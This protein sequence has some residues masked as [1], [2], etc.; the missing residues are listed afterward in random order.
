MSGHDALA[1]LKG[2]S[3]AME[4]VRTQIQRL[5][6]S[7]VPILIQ[8]ETGTGKELCAGAV[9]QLSGRMPFVP[10]NCAAFPESLAESELFGHERGAF[11]GA[12]R[13][14]TGVVA[15]A[16]GGVL[17]LDEL[18]ELPPHMQAKL[19]R[20]LESGEYRPVGSNRSLRSQFRIL[21]ATSGDL[22]RVIAEGRL[23]A[24]L[25]HRLGAVRI[26]MPPLRRRRDDIPLLACEFLHRYLERSE[27]GP[28]RI[29]ADAYAILVAFDWPGNV[30]QL[31]NVVEGAAAMAGLDD[32]IRRA[33][34][35]QFVVPP[36]PDGNSH[37]VPSLAQARRSA[38]QQAIVDA[39]SRVGGNRERAAK[40]LRVSPATLYRRL[41][42][43]QH[44]SA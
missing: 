24:D 6:R 32:T 37:S 12:V 19:L 31:R 41:G 8:G 33:H 7:P 21:A 1:A 30:R 14:H 28:V 36:S 23:R 3:A 2:V 40:L 13:A 10:I 34:V 5:A 9:A 38:E 20:T 15:L 16:N 44:E 4:Q 25:L 11:T 18:G 27:G 42:E 43:R 39:L 17:F 26:S 29:D 22:E 35:L